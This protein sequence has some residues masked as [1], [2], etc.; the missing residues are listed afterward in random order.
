MTIEEFVRRIVARTDG[1]ESVTPSP[2]EHFNR[3]FS[4]EADGV[5]IHSVLEQLHQNLPYSPFG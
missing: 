2:E 5:D 1:F 3:I 4:E